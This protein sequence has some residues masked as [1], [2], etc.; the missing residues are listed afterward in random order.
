MKPFH[1]NQDPLY[2]AAAAIL[3]GKLFEAEQPED[4]YN[5]L[6]NIFNEALIIAKSTFVSSLSNEMLW[7][8]SSRRQ[9][10]AG[11]KSEL[12]ALESKADMLVKN[13]AKSIDK[14]DLGFDKYIK[15]DQNL[16]EETMSKGLLKNVLRVMETQTFSDWYKEDFEGY[17]TGDPDAKTEEEILDDLENLIKNGYPMR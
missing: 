6:K 3:Q 8:I 1:Y 9:I 16:T 7:A 4:D 12:D 15:E 14:M 11:T 13:I 17:I 5:S 2:N 10:N